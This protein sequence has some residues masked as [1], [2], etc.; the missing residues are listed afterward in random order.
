MTGETPTA[1]AYPYGRYN[2]NT[3]LILKEFGF[4]AT[5]TCDYGINQIYR[6]PDCLYHLKRICRAHG[7]RIDILLTEGMKTLRFKS[8]RPEAISPVLHV[9]HVKPAPYVFMRRA[10]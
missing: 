7:Q 3:D 8:R 9:M 5:L 4:R 1:F 6:N 2:K 10:G